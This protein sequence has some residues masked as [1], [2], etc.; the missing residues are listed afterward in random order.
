MASEGQKRLLNSKYGVLTVEIDHQSLFTL[1]WNGG[2]RASHGCRWQP[3]KAVVM[4]DGLWLALKAVRMV[5]RRLLWRWLL[6]N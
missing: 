6:V 3:L 5:A 1:L 2:D 4:G